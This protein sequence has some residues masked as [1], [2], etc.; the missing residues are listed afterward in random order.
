MTEGDVVR[1]LELLIKKHIPEAFTGKVI[2]VD[3]AESKGFVTVLF[4][5]L[6]YDVKLKSVIDEQ[7]AGIFMIPENESDVFCVPEGLDKERYFV[8][9]INKPAKIIIKMQNLS[10]VMD[11]EGSLI[12]FNDGNNNG[13]VKVADLVTKLN[14]IESDLNDIKQVFSTW[15]PVSQDGG[16]AL[17]TAAASWASS[18]ISETQQTDLENDKVK[19]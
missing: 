5:E 3:S 9:G 10:F 4:N 16:A 12:Q 1:E 17:K 11:N 13:L 8:A 6:E 15:T 18:V 2:N 14:T 19:H 7:E